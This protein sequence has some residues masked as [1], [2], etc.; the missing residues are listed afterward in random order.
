MKQLSIFHAFFILIISL[1]FCAASFAGKPVD[2]T[3]LAPM[4]KKILPAVVNVKAQVRV[5]DF[6]ALRELQ[7]QRKLNPESE[8][9]IPPT[10]VSVGSGVIID[11]NKGFVLTN[12]HVVNDAQ[13]VA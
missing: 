5:T 9:G 8:Q 1:F 6:E 7:K 4:L 11:A 12:A 2:T 13:S 3:T 10:A